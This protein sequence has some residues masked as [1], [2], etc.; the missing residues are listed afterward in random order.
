MRYSGWFLRRFIPLFRRLTK[1][2]RRALHAQAPM[3]RYAGG[4]F[5]AA[6]KNRPSCDSACDDIRALSKKATNVLYSGRPFAGQMLS[7]L[8]GIQAGFFFYCDFVFFWYF[9][10]FDTLSLLTCKKLTEIY[11][12]NCSKSATGTFITL[13]LLILCPF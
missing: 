13:S 10:P 3:G 7:I 8:A 9:V 2:G 11:F 5:W 12:S 4:G 1:G 6:S